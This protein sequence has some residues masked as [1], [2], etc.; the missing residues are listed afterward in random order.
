MSVHEFALFFPAIDTM[1]LVAD[2]LVH[3]HDDVL[4]RRVS[5]VL[6]ISVGE[7]VLLFGLQRAARVVLHENAYRFAVRVIDTWPIMPMKPPITVLLPLLE[8]DAFEVAVTQCAVFGVSNIVPI[9]TQKTRRRTLA[10]P[11]RERCTRLMIAAQEQSKQLAR[12]TLAEP[13]MLISLSG[14]LCCSA[15]AVT[16]LLTPSGDLLAQVAPSLST[17]SSITCIVG[18]EGDF[19]DEEYVSLRAGSV[20]SL[21]LGPS[22]L[23]SELALTLALGLTRCIASQ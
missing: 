4:R 5:R 19:T 11:E 3:L 15:S 23:R 17:A 10:L 13:C 12:P 2:A 1:E 14:D 9:V 8:R 16:L 18:P 20:V 6:R 21:Q 7:H 22:I